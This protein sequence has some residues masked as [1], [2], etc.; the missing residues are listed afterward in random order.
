MWFIL[1]FFCSFYGEDVPMIDKGGFLPFSSSYLDDGDLVGFP[2]AG[3]IADVLVL[4]PALLEVAAM[5]YSDLGW[6][7]VVGGWLRKDVMAVRVFPLLTL[8]LGFFSWTCWSLVL[9]LGLFFIFYFCFCYLSV[10]M[11]DEVS[12][13]SD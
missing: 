12:A 10:M 2:S 1:W 3:F 8:D 13:S 6:P 5:G 11:D 7:L 4:W 9:G